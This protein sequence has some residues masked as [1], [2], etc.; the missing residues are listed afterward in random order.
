MRTLAFVLVDGKLAFVRLG[1]QMVLRWVAVQLGEVRGIDEVIYVTKSKHIAQ[2]Y[3]TLGSEARALATPL[4]GDDLYQ[5]LAAEAKA[6]GAE[7]MMVLGMAAPFLRSGSVERCLDKVRNEEVTAALTVHERDGWAGTG[8]LENVS[9]QKVTV[10]VDGVRV[11]K[12][13]AAQ[14]RDRLVCCA[15]GRA[16]LVQVDG[17]EALDISVREGLDMAKAM[18]T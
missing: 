3:D 4:A 1:H 12:L 13:S 16:A 7:I 10:A 15:V 2:V 14:A 6:R 18:V 8:T 9:L 17:R 5:L 11:F